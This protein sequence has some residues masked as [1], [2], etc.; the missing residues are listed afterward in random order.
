MFIV[1]NLN[2]I[3][4]YIIGNAKGNLKTELLS[5]CFYLKFVKRKEKRKITIVDQKFTYTVKKDSMFTS[6]NATI[7]L[8]IP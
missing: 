7:S 5:Q 6:R 4:I 2:Y 3:Y 1:K 8:I